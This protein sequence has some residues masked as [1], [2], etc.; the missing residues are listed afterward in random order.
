MDETGC[1]TDVQKFSVHDGPG[2][3][4]TVFFK[5]CPLDCQWC[6][7]PECISPALQLGYRETRCVKC[8]KC[9]VACPEHAIKSTGKN[10]TDSKC[11]VASGCTACVDACDA[12]ALEIAGKRMTVDDLLRVVL[13]DKDYYEASGGGVTVSGGEPTYQWPF[14]KKF[15][16]ACKVKGISTAMETCGF[17][18]P[19]IIDDLVNTCDI[20]L[21][22]LKHLDS[23][24]H[25]KLTGQPNE[26]ILS[27]L[28]LVH[29]RFS[30]TPGKKFSVRMPLVPGLNDAYEHLLAVENFL[31]KTGI[32]DLVLL[33]YH[34]LYLQKID[35]F[36]LKRKKL[37]IKPHSRE[38]L[39]R[40]G[41]YFT[42]ISV[43][44]GG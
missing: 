20:I 23:A 41:K 38:D 33:P 36:K 42:K 5:G 43:T 40:I 10:I 27:N 2:I 15:L 26:T 12:T 39:D 24:E 17:F 8:G 4:T 3:R 18:N 11:K 28:K 16:L 29:K 7:N 21:F 34:S 31:V 9:A 19:A 35:E 44:F 14:V 13:D 22:D 37:S 30:A 6:Q 25:R 1:V 32:K